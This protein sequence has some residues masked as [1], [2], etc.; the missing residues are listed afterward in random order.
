[1]YSSNNNNRNS[2][3]N[4]YG[5]NR[6][7][8]GN[9]GGYN[10]GGSGS[11]GGRGGGRKIPRYNMQDFINKSPVESKLQEYNASFTFADLAIHPKIKANILSKGYLNPTPIQDQTILLSLEG[12]DVIGLANTGMGKTAAFLI[13]LIEKVLKTDQ[14]VLVIAPTRELALQIDDELKTF[15][16]D[17][18]VYS[19]LCIGGASMGRQ[20][21]E[22]RRDPDFVIGTPGRL[23]DLANRGALK[24]EQYPNIVLDEVDRMLDMGFLPDITEILSRLP[25]E[26]QSLFFSATLPEEIKRIINTFM[27]DPVTVSVVV[28]TTAKNIYQDVITHTRNDNKIDILHKMMTEQNFDKTLVFAATK[29]YA[30]LVCRELNDRGVKSN[31]IHGDKSQAQRQRSLDQFKSSSVK[32][33]VATDVAA[34]GLDISNVTHVIN[35]DLPQ[36]FQDYVHRIGRTGRAGKTGVAL[37]FFE[38][39]GYTSSY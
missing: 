15:A 24:L 35:F 21:Q 14:R 13:P 26:R 23:L 2:G 32:V 29:R 1:M 28:G 37:T 17:A 4:R 22:L 12:K 7:G 30:D 5:G 38:S 3:G 9:R 20:L 25:K 6:G 16:R 34:R 11:R 18:R 27:R 39:N 8:S 33:L 31:A 19:T 36:S 10:R